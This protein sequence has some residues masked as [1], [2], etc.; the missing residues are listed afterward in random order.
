MA[1]KCFLLVNSLKIVIYYIQFLEL[2]IY[3][4]KTGG[5]YLKFLAEEVRKL[6]KKKS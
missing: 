1:W 2:S 5:F 6:L 4:I 3:V